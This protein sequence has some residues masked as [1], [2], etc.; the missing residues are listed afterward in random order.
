MAYLN[1]L[2]SGKI[3]SIEFVQVNSLSMYVD[4]KIVDTNMNTTITVCACW[5]QEIAR[6]YSH[7][8]KL[9]MNNVDRVTL[10]RR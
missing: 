10:R 9:E 1:Q 4:G 2:L 8:V 7:L 5:V 6:I 3:C